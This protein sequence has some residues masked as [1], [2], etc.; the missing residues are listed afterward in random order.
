MDNVFDGL[1]M[2]LDQMATYYQ[3]LLSKINALDVGGASDEVL[4]KLEEIK[5]LLVLRTSRVAPTEE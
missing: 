5:Q 2:I 4:A 3:L 1:M